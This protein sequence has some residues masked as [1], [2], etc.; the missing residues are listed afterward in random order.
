[1]TAKT[2]VRSDVSRQCHSL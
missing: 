2:T 1:M